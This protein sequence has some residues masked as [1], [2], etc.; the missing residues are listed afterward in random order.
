MITDNSDKIFTRNADNEEFNIEGAQSRIKFRS[1]SIN[2]SRAQRLTE[3]QEKLEL[4]FS[5]L[6]IDLERE[7]ENRKNLYNSTHIPASSSAR[8]LRWD[9]R[10]DTLELTRLRRRS[11][12]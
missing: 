11:R 12:V 4:N 6:D 5:I 2:V 3:Y 7:R 9:E 1:T 10:S 8:R